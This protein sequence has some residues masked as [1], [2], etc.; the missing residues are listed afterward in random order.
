MTAAETR[1]TLLATGTYARDGNEISG[2]LTFD[3]RGT[4]AWKCDL[5]RPDD[6]GI[7]Q[8]ACRFQ[9]TGKF[10]TDE[11]TL[12]YPMYDSRAAEEFP[13][14]VWHGFVSLEGYTVR[15]E[16]EPGAKCIRVFDQRQAVPWMP[17]EERAA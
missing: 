11:A 10:G 6:S 16:I 4:F 8:Q 13:P 17:E 12:Y 9:I 5:I 2:T 15:I 3:V 7:A 14:A 1:A